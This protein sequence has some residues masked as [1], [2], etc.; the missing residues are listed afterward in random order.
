MHLRRLTGRLLTML[1]FCVLCFGLLPAGA[2]AASFSDVPK[3]HWAYDAI[4]ATEA[5]GLIQ[6][7]GGKFRPGDSVSSQAFLSMVCRAWGL[8]DRKLE[9]GDR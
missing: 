9:S 4:M 8:D 3:N 6:G 7:S 2:K 1:L 5:Q